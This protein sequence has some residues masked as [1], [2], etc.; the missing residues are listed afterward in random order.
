MYIYGIRSVASNIRYRFSGRGKNMYI[1]LSLS[2]VLFERSEFLIATSKKKKTVR[3]CVW[4][5]G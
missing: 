1:F 3:L 4:M 5:F 2:I